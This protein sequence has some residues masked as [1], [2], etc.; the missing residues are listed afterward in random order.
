MS[1]SVSVAASEAAPLSVETLNQG[2]V[3]A[4]YAVR[5]VLLERANAYAKR[6]AD[7][8]KLPFDEL[9]K[10][11]VRR[12]RPPRL[13]LPSRHIPRSNPQ[14]KTH[15][16][17]GNPQALRQKPITFFRQVLS[18]VSYPALLEAPAEALAASF[19]PDAVAR[20]REFLAHTPAGT[21]AYSDSKGVAAVR[22]DVADFVERR[23]GL[24]GV[25]PDAV[26]LTNGASQGIHRLLQMVIRDSSDAVLVPVPQYPLYS[27]T[28]ALLGGTFLGYGLQEE[29]G[30]SLDVAALRRQ[31]ADAR[32]AGLSP[33]ALVVVS[34]GNPSGSLLGEADL[35][36]L[37]RLC[38][39]EHLVLVA[40]EVYQENI[41]DDARPFR[42][43]RSVVHGA[44]LAGR[45]QLAS[46][47]STSKGFFGECGH[48]GGYMQLE[49]FD[50]AVMAQLTKLASVSLCS[51]VPGQ[52]AVSC[53]V[54]PPAPG[55]ASHAAYEAERDAILG[56]LRRRA[57]ALVA[58]LNAMEGVSC[59][60]AAG[61]LYAFPRVTLPPRACEAARAEGLEPD[62]FY[63]VRLLDRTGIVVVP[64][65]G[66][67]QADG[68]WHFRTTF[69]PP[70]DKWDKVVRAMGEA[71]A[72]FM[73]EFSD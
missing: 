66:F 21:G 16:Q 49:G 7:G 68:T 1:V 41:Y 26:F 72:A 27:A 17:I 43:M 39:D 33:R 9:F 61:A 24:G 6:L 35:E 38:A 2:V 4:K 56:S 19:A 51:N 28:I 8:E 34:P 52:L 73:A 42:S 15:A 64:G 32:A 55:D 62:A 50:K 69:L 18:L 29:T 30:W 3:K 65:S 37:A 45:V 46:Y 31:V 47:H 71:H 5:G 12:R 70:E 67:G 40:D 53:M 23:D 58:A 14:K 59:Q 20:A 13:P 48:R 57:V 10:C 36:A 54:R 22:R 63:C 60:P 25:D 44:G 11:N